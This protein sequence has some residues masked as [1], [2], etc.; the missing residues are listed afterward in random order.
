MS[1]IGP[2]RL[3]KAEDSDIVERRVACSQTTKIFWISSTMRE[4]FELAVQTFTLLF[5]RNFFYYSF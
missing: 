1:L 2:T 5:W 4:K 3:A